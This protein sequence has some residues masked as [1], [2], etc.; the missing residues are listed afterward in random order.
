[1]N[2]KATFLFKIFAIILLFSNL[3]WATIDNAPN[4]I[5]AAQNILHHPPL[6]ADGK[7]PVA[8]AFRLINLSGIA[9]E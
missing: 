7:I 9:E 3:A 5:S 1:M 8:L 6:N 4:T 2:W